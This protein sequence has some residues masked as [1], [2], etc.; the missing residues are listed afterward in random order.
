MKLQLQA[1]MYVRVGNRAA[2]ILRFR[3]DAVASICNHGGGISEIKVK[4][5]VDHGSRVVS[6]VGIGC[7]VGKG[8]D[9]K[10]DPRQRIRHRGEMQNW[11]FSIRITMRVVFHK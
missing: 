5:L 8:G 6:V 3:E 10:R 1:W 7:G 11:K 2:Y 9:P 4:G